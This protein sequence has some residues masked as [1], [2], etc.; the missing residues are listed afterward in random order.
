MPYSDDETDAD[1]LSEKEWPDESDTAAPASIDLAPCPYCRKMIFAE[2]E[3]CPHCRNFISFE[4][5][6]S[7]RKPYWFILGVVLAILIMLV[8]VFF[9]L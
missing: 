2:A 1:D 7:Q 3:I 4:D 6:R 8:W 9:R 5:Q